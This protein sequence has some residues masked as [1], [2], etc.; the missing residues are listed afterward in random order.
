MTKEPYGSGRR[1]FWPWSSYRSTVGLDPAR[2]FLA[3]D[4][5][6]AAFAPQ[7][8]RAK[9]RLRAFVAAGL[10]ARP[11]EELRGQVFLGSETFA[12]T[13]AS[14]PR[15][16]RDIPRAQRQPVRPPLADLLAVDG[17]R[18]IATAYRTFGYRLAEIA[19]QLGLHPTTVGRRLR[20]LEAGGDV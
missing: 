10:A 11:F 7:P 1:A 17:E 12:A 14:A 8:A 16:T 5:L 15:A 19:D 4:E 9:R 3:A 20:A 18:A 13:Y 6:L 2:A